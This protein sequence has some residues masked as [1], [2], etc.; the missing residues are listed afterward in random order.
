[1]LEA[2]K[3][4]SSDAACKNLLFFV[5]LG[6]LDDAN[7]TIRKQCS[8]AP[9]GPPS[10]PAFVDKSLGRAIVG[11]VVDSE[12]KKPIQGAVVSISNFLGRADVQTD[13]RGV[14]STPGIGEGTEYKITVEHEGYRGYTG[15]IS[16]AGAYP[17]TISL[18]KDR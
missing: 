18:K 16:S 2:I 14:F 17:P 6:L 10:L 1:V 7:K 15:I 4:G 9:S 5:G 11:F 12:S 8:S 3:T 13:S